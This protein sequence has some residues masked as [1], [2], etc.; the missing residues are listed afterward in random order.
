MISINKNFS[1]FILCIVIFYSSF[2]LIACK[3]DQLPDGDQ[4]INT[5]LIESRNLALASTKAELVIVGR[6]VRIDDSPHCG[7]WHWGAIA[8]YTDLTILS[9]SY[10]YDTV[11][12]IHGCPELKRGDYAEGSGDLE[13]FVARDYHELHLTQDNV[14]GIGLHPTSDQKLAGRL[15]YS[16]EVNFY[17]GD[18]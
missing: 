1:R 13:A 15:Y 6:L 3:Q 10:A 8:E 14:Y 12:V 17:K 7:I 9:G 16:Q 11:L 5:N 2:L 18:G 4:G